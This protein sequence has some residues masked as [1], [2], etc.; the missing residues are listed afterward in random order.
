MPNVAAARAIKKTLAIEK[1]SRP[2]VPQRARNEFLP[3]KR[4]KLVTQR[5]PECT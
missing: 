3:C 5:S 4:R 1:T 2:K